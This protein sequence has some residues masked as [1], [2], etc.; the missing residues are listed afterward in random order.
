MLATGHRVKMITTLVLAFVAG[1]V[2]SVAVVSH[3]HAH[4]HRVPKTV[5]MKGKQE[6]QTGLKVGEYSWS[7]PSGDDGTCVAEQAVLETRF[8]TADEVAAKSKLRLK[9]F[10][11][12]RP[13]SFE[14]KAYRKVD[15]NGLPVGVGR[16]LQRTLKPVVRDGKPVAWNA[17]F[18]VNRPSRHYYLVAEGHWKDKQGCRSE[19]FAL[20]S[21]HVKTKAL[22]S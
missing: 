5:L 16:P 7:Y 6:M 13:D 10:K 17:I 11:S 18:Q 15:E 19:Q 9:I 21:F 20:W 22:V 2:A 1:L 14:I 4:D 3:A 8:R 12:Q